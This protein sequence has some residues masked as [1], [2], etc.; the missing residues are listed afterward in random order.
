MS[1]PYLFKTSRNAIILDFFML[2]IGMRPCLVL[3]ALQ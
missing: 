1:D 2:L 3:P